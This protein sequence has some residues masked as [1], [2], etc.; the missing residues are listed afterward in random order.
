M[1][2]SIK[3]KLGITF[4][5]VIVIAASVGLLAIRDLAVLDTAIEELIDG[6]AQR[7]QVGERLQTVFVTL[8]N[9]EKNLILSDDDQSIDRYDAEILAARKELGTLEEQLR[10]VS[11][12][13]GRQQID[14]FGQS[15]A[16]YVAVQDKVRGLAR[17]DTD[18]K[19]KE[20][21]QGAGQRAAETL[22]ASLRA[23]AARLPAEQA[24]AA[25]AVRDM[26]AG[27]LQLQRLEKDIVLA[28]DEMLPQYTGK[29]APVRADI[30]RLRDEIDTA[31][32]VAE[33]QA[34]REI[35]SQMDAWLKLVDQVVALGIENTNTKAFDLSAGQGRQLLEAAASQL[36]GIIT[37][38]TRV[39]AERRDATA[40]LYANTRNIVAVAL[41]VSVLL[42]VGAAVWLARSIGRVLIEAAAAADNVSAGSQQLSA[43][44]EQLSQGS[45][46]QASA[47]E[48][49]AASMEQMSANVKRNAENAS[50]TEHIARQSA[51]DAQASGTAVA[52]AVQAV[53]T[54]AEKITVVQEIARQTDLLALNAAVEAARAGEHGRGFAVVASEVRKLAERSQAAATEIGAV[55]GQTLKAAHAAGEMLTGLVPDIG[56][57]AELVAEI[58]AACREQ[59]T[60]AEQINQA[61]QQLDKVTQQNAG[62]AEE[63][64]ATSEELAA[65]AEQLQSVIAFLRTGAPPAV[66]SPARSAEPSPPGR[67]E[68]RRPEAAADGLAARPRGGREAVNR[69][70]SNGHSDGTGLRLNLGSDS[71]DREFVHY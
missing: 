53:H 19:A 68:A 37:Q 25:T 10:A 30:V 46:E 39:M 32:P 20:L 51:K 43:A 26:L 14:T 41:L 66:S 65:Q 45:T 64:S 49:A 11:D 12:A 3:S 13:A 15:V 69:G 4:G 22:E 6:P 50:Q 23:L 7:V 55:S 21:S 67:R 47:G 54:I 56:K 27:V 17:R 24:R 40:S 71:H 58:S 52:Q 62:A 9:A 59:D 29:V 44:A 5:A 28:S 38:S 61:I 8:A 60:G 31:L 1:R 33:R 36:R 48:E 35:D 63:M 34:A 57:T 42:G 2:L 70:K 18:A 16:A